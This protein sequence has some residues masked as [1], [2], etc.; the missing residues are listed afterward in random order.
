M[1]VFVLCKARIFTSVINSRSRG[2]AL[3]IKNK[4]RRLLTG[5]ESGGQGRD[6]TADTGIFSPLLYRLS[7]LTK[8]ERDLIELFLRF[9]VK[10][11]FVL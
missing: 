5:V 11:I 2:N 10:F 6:R 3:S 9:F 8:N 7:Y 1:Q 4:K